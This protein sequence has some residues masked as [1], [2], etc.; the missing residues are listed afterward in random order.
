MH[1]THIRTVCVCADPRARLIITIESNINEHIIISTTYNRIFVYW[2]FTANSV[3]ECDKESEWE[4]E[5]VSKRGDTRLFH[6]KGHSQRHHAVYSIEI[7]LANVIPLPIYRSMKITHNPPKWFS[8]VMKFLFGH[9]ANGTHTKAP[10]LPILAMF[11]YVSA[12][13][14]VIAS[15]ISVFQF[16]F[17]KLYRTDR[18]TDWPR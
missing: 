3:C 11:L 9:F 6:W 7:T 2:T 4:R 12:C 16:V 17:E 10:A 8:P 13:V 18:Q 14:S 15:G 5:R 1:T